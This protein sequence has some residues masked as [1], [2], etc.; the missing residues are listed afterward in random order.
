MELFND[1]KSYW[2]PGKLED[3]FF[4]AFPVGAALLALVL[5]YIVLYARRH[6]LPFSR[7]THILCSV[8]WAGGLAA[9][10][11]GGTGLYVWSAGLFGENP[12]Q[13]GY[14]LGF[15]IC[16][17][18]AIWGVAS[19]ANLQSHERVKNL[20]K[21]PATH[22]ERGQSVYA[23]RN[24][25][26]R[27]K[28]VAWLTPLAA[29][30]MLLPIFRQP[31]NKLLCVALDNSFSM[32][33]STPS[34]MVPLQVGK[35]A[36][37]RTVQ[38]LGPKTDF[39]LGYFD[40]GRSK[41]SVPALTSAK[42]PQNLSGTVL[43]YSGDKS[44]AAA[45]IQNLPV[46]QNGSPVAETVWKT[47]LTAKLSDQE[48]HYEKR[49]LVVITDGLENC[50]K[51]NLNGL[52]CDQ[53]EFAE[54]FPPENVKIVKLEEVI[55]PGTLDS[56]NEFMTKVRECGYAELDGATYSSYQDAINEV[57]ADVQSDYSFPVWL[58]I[59]YILYALVLLFQNPKQN[60]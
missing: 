48:R 28:V 10:L 31:Q 12:Y 60:L 34:G 55:I 21:Q 40:N 32:G 53:I 46:G 33:S 54:F 18:V 15:T 4:W 50:V 43:I 41:E 58:L 1:F 30:I 51:G 25:F 20:I 8:A 6:R 3:P 35:D 37:T 52:F 49:F 17:A 2:Q 9:A 59:L 45:Q 16:L 5:A 26:D 19:L 42:S 57:M 39:I 23:L 36:L 11:V 29:T 13:G 24:T 38:S 7:V 56:S 14:L 47:Y 22:F 44:E 27:L